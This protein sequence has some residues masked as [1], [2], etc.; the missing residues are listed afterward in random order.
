[1]NRADAVARWLEDADNAGLSITAVNPING[2]TRRLEREELGALLALL[3]DYEAALARE[4][5]ARPAPEVAAELQE[6]GLDPQWFGARVASARPLFV[7]SRGAININGYTLREL[8]EL[9]RNPNVIDPKEKLIYI[10]DDDDALRELLFV[11]ISQ[12]GFQSDIFASAKEM[13]EGLSQRVPDLLVLD[14]MM[15]GTGG[16]ELIQQLQASDARRVPVLIMTGRHMDN[17]TI[18]TLKSEPNVAGFMRKPVRREE[19]VKIL[20]AMLGTRL[21]TADKPHSV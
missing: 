14:L 20:H 6:T 5:G 16:L 9:Y 15:P 10:V 3:A 18:E 2:H 21:K 11:Q 12:E 1:M 13:L 7:A 17:G 8:L 4:E 19:L